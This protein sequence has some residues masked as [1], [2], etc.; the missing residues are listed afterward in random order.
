LAHGGVGWSPN[1]KERVRRGYERAENGGR[2]RTSGVG[3]IKGQQSPFHAGFDCFGQAAFICFSSRSS[4]SHLRPRFFPRILSSAHV[5]LFSVGRLG[6]TP[7]VC[8]LSFL[9]TYHRAPIIHSPGICKLLDKHIKIS[10]NAFFNVISLWRS[11]CF[12]TS[13]K[14]VISRNE[15]TLVIPQLLQL[16]TIIGLFILLHFVHFSVKC[17]QDTW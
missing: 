8:S 2:L 17:K 16:Q 1:D 6:L 9:Y 3:N 11:Y 14:S 7:L 13:I 4:F 5:R 15:M 10:L 12:A